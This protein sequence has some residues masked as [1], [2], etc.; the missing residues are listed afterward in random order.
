M[1]R[2]R[3]IVSALAV[4]VLAFGGGLDSAHAAT[5]ASAPEFTVLPTSVLV[6]SLAGYGGQLNQH[7]YADLS[8]PPPDLPGLEGKVLAFEPQF[9]RVFFNT[10]E[11]TFADRMASFER[12]VLLA[13]RAN[14]QIDVTWQGSTVPYALSHMSQ[15]ADVLTDLLR[16][17]E[18]ESLWVTLFNEPNSTKITLPQYE[19]VY[20]TLDREL[21]DRGV[22]DRIRFMG[23]DLVLDGQAAWFDYMAAHMGDLLDA[24]SIHVFWDF[25]DTGKIESRLAGVRQVFS[26]LPAAQRRPLY[27]AEFGVRGIRSF[28]GERI[29]EPG[30]WLDGAPMPETNVA[31]F[32]EAWFVVRAAE[33]GFVAASKW[34]FF[35]ATYDAGTQDYS[36]IGPGSAG[37]PLRPTY[38]VMRL[39]TLAARPTWSIVDVARAPGAD[40]AKLA[41]A[42]ASPGGNVSVVGLD[43]EGAQLNG[44]LGR[45]VSWSIGG[46]P[47]KTLFRLLLW[48]GDGSGTTREVGYLDSGADGVARFDAPLGSVFALTSA[49]YDPIFG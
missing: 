27:I 16:T 25:W 30:E 6:G 18:V 32:Q 29:F 47:A 23:G 4:A 13:R 14:A 17:H 15:F 39:F 9:V 33:L 42:Y 35:D 26:R 8:G 49:P 37:W 24:W 22:R 11:W 40:P 46:L 10:T 36:M 20:R 21:R 19:Q 1:V 34:D 44:E 31:A 38:N 48:N 2:P 41:A 28:E 45:G 43:T 7:V 5:A 3:A 12:A